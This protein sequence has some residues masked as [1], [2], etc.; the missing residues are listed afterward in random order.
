[1]REGVSE[2]VREGEC[3]CVCACEGVSESVCA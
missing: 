1:M 2:S 3:E